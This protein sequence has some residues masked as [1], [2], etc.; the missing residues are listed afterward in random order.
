MGLLTRLGSIFARHP[1]ATHPISGDPR[2]PDFDAAADADII[3][4]HPL[5]DLDDPTPDPSVVTTRPV[6][7]ARPPARRTKQ[8]WFD[9]LQRNHQELTDLI[10]KF[11]AHLDSSE[12]RAE[13][14]MRAA[15]ALDRVAPSIETLSHTVTDQVSAAAERITSA[16]ETASGRAQSSADNAATAFNAI[17]E[18]LHQS[19]AGQ[20]ELV[21]RLAEFRQSMTEVARTGA[22]STRLLA[23][24]SQ[25]D[26]ERQTRLDQRLA[27]TRLWLVLGVTAAFVLS[28]AAIAVAVIAITKSS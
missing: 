3:D 23:E 2:P 4:E 12:Q 7:L 25:R 6:H 11:D 13:R 1:G 28:A 26:A 27:S 17:A 20:T 21:T 9:E 14:L 18:H 15:D 19:N 22:E 24:M 16:V 8:E 10:R 5:D